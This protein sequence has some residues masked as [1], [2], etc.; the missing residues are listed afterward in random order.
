MCGRAA[1]EDLY[2]RV[3]RFAEDTPDRYALT[4]YYNAKTARRI[5]FEGRAQMG[6]F[7]ATMVLH[8]RPRGLAPPPPP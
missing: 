7:G 4:D 6:G 8:E 1:V 2:A 5:G 3:A